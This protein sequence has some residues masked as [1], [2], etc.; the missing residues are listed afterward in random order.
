LG[1]PGEPR[2]PYQDDVPRWR[3]VAAK[4]L[5]VCTLLRSGVQLWIWKERTGARCHHGAED[6][7]K[8]RIPSPPGPPD[9]RSR[10]GRFG[11]PGR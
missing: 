1:H 7:P 4:K 11:C 6:A 8:E 9:R 2:G 10:R 5:T 3:L